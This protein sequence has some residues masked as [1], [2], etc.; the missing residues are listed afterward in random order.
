[1]KLEFGLTDPRSVFPRQLWL[2]LLSFLDGQTLRKT[3]RVN[4]KWLDLGSDPRLEHISKR[5]LVREIKRVK[6]MD[7]VSF[8]FWLIA[9][10][11]EQEKFVGGSKA[12]QNIVSLK[13]AWILHFLP[14]FPVLTFLIISGGWVMRLGLFLWLLHFAI[15]TLY[16]VIRIILQW[17]NQ[18]SFYSLV[19]GLTG[20]FILIPANLFISW[21]LNNSTVSPLSKV[22]LCAL[23]CCFQ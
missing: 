12:R 21:E 16:L 22:S 11:D 7:P 14:L 3:L 4:K 9:R 1:M 17:S 15:R 5:N 13:L 23:L 20:F 8:F 18:T 6:E 19:N 2:H 10:K